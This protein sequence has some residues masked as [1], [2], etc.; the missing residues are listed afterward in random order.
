VEEE[1]YYSDGT[2]W[3]TNRRLIFDSREYPLAH[4]ANAEMKPIYPRKTMQLRLA[5]IVTA[6]FLFL[7][8]ILY[9][10]PFI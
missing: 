1:T 5:T 10:S 8:L 9:G 7:V 4:I 6:A 2:N 3:I